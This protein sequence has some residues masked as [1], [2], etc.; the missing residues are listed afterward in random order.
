MAREETNIYRKNAML[1]YL[2]EFMDDANDFSWQYA[3]AANAV[4]LCR[5][6][7]RKEE[8]IETRK[9]DRIRRAHAQRPNTQQFGSI[10]FYQRGIC[11]NQRDYETE[12]IFYKH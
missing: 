10:R 9:I 4:L 12:G 2:D 8:W 6:E 3:K 11:Q 7:E 1:E 5:M